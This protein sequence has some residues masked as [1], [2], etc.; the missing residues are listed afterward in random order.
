M[1]V[2]FG[3]GGQLDQYGRRILQQQFIHC[4]GD[5]LQFCVFPLWLFHGRDEGYRFPH[6]GGQVD[7]DTARDK[8]AS[9]GLQVDFSV[10]IDVHAHV[11]VV[12]ARVA[13]Q[14][15][16][17]IPLRNDERRRHEPL[18]ILVDVAVEIKLGQPRA[19]DRIGGEITRNV[20]V[21]ADIANHPT[22]VNGPV[23][24][25]AM[26]KVGVFKG[27]SSDSGKHAFGRLWQRPVVGQR[28]HGE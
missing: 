3:Q 2:L 10:A 7:R 28:N 11:H 5:L 24:E 22:L 27:R 1:S 19:L 13:V 23:P 8:A 16:R 9:H 20:S 18:G 14:M 25:V 17:Q 15:E 4:Q 6:D 26:L 21:R 12:V